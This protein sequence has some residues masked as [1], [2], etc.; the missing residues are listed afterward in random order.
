MPH[1]DL[2]SRGSQELCLFFFKELQKYLS[3]VGRKENKISCVTFT[4]NRN[5]FVN[6]YHRQ[7]DCIRIYFRGIIHKIRGL[8]TRPRFKIITKIDGSGWNKQYPHYIEVKKKELIPEIVKIVC[9]HAY[10]LSV[11][12]KRSL[13]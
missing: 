13:K 10:P 6:V 7:D 11:K 2:A 3:N 4:P 12:K 1:H 9:N 8:K 5:Q